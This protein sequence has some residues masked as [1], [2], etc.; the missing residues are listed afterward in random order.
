MIASWTPSEI[1]LRASSPLATVR[2][3]IPLRRRIASRSALNARSS[4]ITS[5][6]T[7]DPAEPGQRTPVSCL[8]QL[9]DAGANLSHHAKKLSVQKVVDR[10]NERRSGP[11]RARALFLCRSAHLHDVGGLA[12]GHHLHNDTLPDGELGLFRRRSPPPEIFPV[13]CQCCRATSRLT[14]AWTA[15][16]ARTSCRRAGERRDRKSA[17]CCR[18]SA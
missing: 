3:E 4:S 5:T 14:C 16:R 17:D 8:R 1:A 13:M 15:C 7:Q 6:D 11:P 18:S 10:L 9:E 12:V 2:V